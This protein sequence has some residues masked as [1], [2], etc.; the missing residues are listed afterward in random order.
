MTTDT[1]KTVANPARA[2]RTA[3]TGKTPPVIRDKIAA[4]KKG[5]WMG[6]PVPLGYDVRDRKPRDRG[7]PRRP[8]ADRG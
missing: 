2:L 4:S 8:D 5:M 1:T 3:I 6:G 7:S